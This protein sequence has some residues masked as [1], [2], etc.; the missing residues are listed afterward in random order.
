[1]YIMMPLVTKTCFMPFLFSL[2]MGCGDIDTALLSTFVVVVVKLL[3]LLLLSIH[4]RQWINRWP[5]RYSSVRSQYA[6][7]AQV[8]FRNARDAYNKQKSKTQKVV[9]IY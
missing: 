6:E 1:M 4:S 3:Q 9:H 5:V 2:L 8:N 7:Q